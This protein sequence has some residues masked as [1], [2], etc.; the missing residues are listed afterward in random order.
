MCRHSFLSIFQGSFFIPNCK[1]FLFL[2]L[3]FSCCGRVLRGLKGC[4]LWLKLLPRDFL[5]LDD[6]QNRYL[7]SFFRKKKLLCIK[8]LLVLIKA[9]KRLHQ[10]VGGKYLEANK[11]LTIRPRKHEYGLKKSQTA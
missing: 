8:T 7:W 2:K 1:I 4:T 11:I 9:K 3:L 6:A 10:K 5:I